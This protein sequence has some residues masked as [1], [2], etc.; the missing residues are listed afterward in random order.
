MK[1]VPIGNDDF[2]DLRDNEG[3]YVDKSN[4]IQEILSKK[5]TK[6]FLFTRPRR[7]GK[8]LNMSMID[9]FFNM[10]YKGND[11]FEGLN[12]SCSKELMDV[13]NTCPVISMDLKGLNLVDMQ[14]FLD[15]F[16]VKMRDLCIGHGTEELEIEGSKGWRDS[17]EK[18]LG[19]IKAKKY[20]H[21]LE[22]STLL[23]GICFGGKEA[24]VAMEKIDSKNL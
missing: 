17:A 14:S 8:T 16:S 24:K 9:A 1:D 4:L 6:V 21:G 18:A 22:G 15:S 20:H 5:N 10:K 2:K 23:Y 11:W 7:F 3:H 19:Q 13:R 12:I